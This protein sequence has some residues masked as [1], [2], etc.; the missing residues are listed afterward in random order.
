MTEF[1]DIIEIL[2]EKPA[3][4][5]IVSIAYVAGLR[6]FPNAALNLILWFQ[7]RL[8]ISISNSLLENLRLKKEVLGEDPDPKE[9]WPFSDSV[10]A[11]ISTRP[12][13]EAWLGSAGF[14]IYSLVFFANFDVSE[15]I[16][17]VRKIVVSDPENGGWDQ[18]L[19]FVFGFFAI[20]IV[21]S[22]IGAAAVYFLGQLGKHKRLMVTPFL[23]GVAGMY[24]ILI[25]L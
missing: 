19:G 8:K 3:I 23:G 6:F 22:L 24:I 7:T 21:L 14:L 2:G 5:A 13:L 25:L 17:E 16:A 20:T 1:F 9:S 18:A 12:F 4:A 15:F 10:A 11:P